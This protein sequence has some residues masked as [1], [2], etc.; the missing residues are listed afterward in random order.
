MLP[1]STLFIDT[2]YP[3]DNFLTVCF[4]LVGIAELKP[5]GGPPHIAEPVL[6]SYFIVPFLFQYLEHIL[7][8]LLFHGFAF[9]N[10][11]F[12]IFFLRNSFDVLYVDAL[13]LNPIIKSKGQYLALH[14]I[15]VLMIVTDL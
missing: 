7:F 11:I 14:V 6:F 10:N 2:I 12:G 13:I 1:N 3:T 8:L 4:S 5:I 9:L 15:V